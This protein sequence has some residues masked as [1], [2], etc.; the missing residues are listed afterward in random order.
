MTA[1]AI[2]IFV[3][4]AIQA[5]VIEIQRLSFEDQSR[6]VSQKCCLDRRFFRTK[7][8]IECLT[9]QYPAILTS[10]LVIK[11]ICTYALFQSLQSLERL[12]YQPMLGVH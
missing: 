3:S 12:R 1:K 6:R 10:R 4:R 2:A 9:D 7:V 5:F 11:Q 8:A